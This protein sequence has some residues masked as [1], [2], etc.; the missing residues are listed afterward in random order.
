MKNVERLFSDLLVIGH[1]GSRI[2]EAVLEVSN[3]PKFL[4]GMVKM[5]GA[6]V[7]M[8]LEEEKRVENCLGAALRAEANQ[9]HE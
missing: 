2:V 9:N 8:D 1:P 4:A 7:L 5:L 3:D 6:A